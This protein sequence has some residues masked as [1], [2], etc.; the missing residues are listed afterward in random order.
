MMKQTEFP[1]WV[2]LSTNHRRLFEA[3]QDEWLDGGSE[4]VFIGAEHHVDQPHKTPAGAHPI[5]V[6]ITL[7]SKKLIKQ[8]GR[9]C[10]L[11]NYQAEEQLRAALVHVGGG[12]RV[13]RWP[14][15]VPLKAADLIEVAS[16]EEKVRL[17]GMAGQFSNV[18]L[19][20]PVRVA[21]EYRT[22]DPPD[23]LPKGPIRH[24]PKS[25]NAI[26]GA[27]TMALAMLPG[28]HPFTETLALS[29]NCEDGSQLKAAALRRPMSARWLRMPWLGRDEDNA[30]LSQNQRLW[31]A[32]VRVMQWP[33]DQGSARNIAEKIAAE[34]TRAGPNPKEEAWLEETRKL[35]RGD[36][37]LPFDGDCPPGLA[38]QMA[39]CRPDPMRYVTWTDFRTAAREPSVLWGGAILCG[40]RHGYAML[41]KS[42][43]GDLATRLAIGDRAARAATPPVRHMSFDRNDRVRPGV[44]DQTFTLEFHG[45]PLAVVERGRHLKTEANQPAKGALPDAGPSP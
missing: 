7:D 39:L 41:D 8:W 43:R 33:C 18:V 3:A 24:L 40:W 20:V 15:P 35:L 28:A 2:G 19:P 31:Q 34:A 6:R 11:P 44:Q 45:G 42:L 38:I 12:R 14:G 21:E 1:E 4:G 5:G 25:I 37:T 30:Q 36:I 29:L 26:Q 32:A 13:A 22:W 17:E 9:A 23:G 27:M 16:E 10:G